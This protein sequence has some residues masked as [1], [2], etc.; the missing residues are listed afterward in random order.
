MHNRKL[1]LIRFNI[2]K[3]CHITK[4]GHIGSAFSI[5]EIVYVILKIYKEKLFCFK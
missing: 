4:E 2:L 1:N 5:L 3:S